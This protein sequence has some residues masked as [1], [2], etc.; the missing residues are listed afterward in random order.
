[1]TISI[2]PSIEQI[3][4]SI[5]QSN[6][7]NQTNQSMNQLIYPFLDKHQAIEELFFKY[8]SSSITTCRLQS[9]AL[10]ILL[11]DCNNCWINAHAWT[12]DIF[13]QII[14]LKVTWYDHLSDVKHCTAATEVAVSFWCCRL[15]NITHSRFD[16]MCCQH[17]VRS[18]RRGKFSSISNFIFSVLAR[19]QSPCLV[20]KLKFNYACMFCN[21][22]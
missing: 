20:F 6:Q 17:D 9:A 13:M 7:I 12:G 5:N 1:M 22:G 14:M 21:E 15:L 16:W 18:Q 4:Q 3:N 8:M 10:D 2:H 19:I 11:G